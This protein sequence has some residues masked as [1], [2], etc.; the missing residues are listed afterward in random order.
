[1]D[2]T[3]LQIFKYLP[4]AKK[5]ADSNCKKCGFPTCM[6][7]ALKLAKKQTDLEKCPHIPSE[8]KEK[9]LESTKIQQH[10]LNITPDLKTG[11][12]NVMF[13]H[14]KTF[15]NRTIIAI[16]LDA[17]DIN[18][19]SKLSSIKNYGIDRV[20]ENFQ[21][22]AIWLENPNNDA[23]KKIGNIPVI[24][25]PDAQYELVSGNTIEELA[26]NSNNSKAKNKILNFN[27]EK[28]STIQIINELT[29]IRRQA[30]LKR[31]EPLTYPVLVKL[32]PESDLNKICALASMLICKYANIIVLDEFNPALISTL[33]TLR[34]N[35]YTNPQKPLQVES[36]VYEF[37]EPDENS[38]VLM[39]T[40]FAL[41]YFAVANELESMP[42]GSYLIVTPSDGM[43][44]LTAWSA[45][46]FNSQI[47]AKM[48]SQINL[49]EKV[50][51]RE[52]IIPGLLSHMK[53]ELEE[54]LPDWKIIV[55][56]I[57]AFQLYDFIK[58]KELNSL[59]SKNH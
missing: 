52:I 27:I 31:Y 47:V 20:G 17:D 23:L 33:Y 41:T 29:Q 51:R 56:T 16:N 15:V 12:E 32:A 49:A 45:D 8:L 6:A 5:T 28:K 7:F 53:E 9:F 3:G 35:I 40:N 18:F 10:E 37:N 19:E 25:S 38:V 48:M 43:S 34:Q 46:K 24:N 59:N 36:K 13:R 58:N 26:E 54:A 42:F 11:G 57:E 14:D 30:I 1:M 2:L 39:T 22:D 21:I 44:V 50:K 4:G 55:G